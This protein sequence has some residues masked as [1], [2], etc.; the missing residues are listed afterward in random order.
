MKLICISDT[1][2]KHAQI[3]IPPG[4]VLIHAGDITEGGTKREVV[5]FLK[6]FSSQPHE[7][8]IFIAGNHDFYF[9]KFNEEEIQEIIPENVHYLKES[10]IIINGI[11]FWGSPVTPG[12]GTWAF[13][14][15]QTQE[16]DAHWEQIPKDTKVLISH[17]PP[18][19][20]K[21]VLNNGRHI[22]CASL[23][24]TIE[25]RKIKFHI[26][27]HVHDSYGITKVGGT[28]FINASCL[29]NKYRYLHPPL[30]FDIN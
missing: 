9:E 20:I 6:W 26:F 4:D 21:D 11:K 1:H 28:K 27:G 5:D 23:F 16:T 19:K 10:G 3:P 30:E 25:K 12:D 24:K 7:H 13:N 14:Q 29:D 22:G 15:K 2:N 18:Y 17:T 8:K